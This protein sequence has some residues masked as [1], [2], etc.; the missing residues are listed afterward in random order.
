MLALPC[1]RSRAVFA[2][3]RRLYASRQT[4]LREKQRMENTIDRRNRN[5]DAGN[6]G[7]RCRRENDAIKS[8]LPRKSRGPLAY[9]R[10]LV[11]PLYVIV[12]SLMGSAVSMT[13]KVPEH[14][15]RALDP[16]EP[17][18]N[19]QAREYLVFQ[20]MQVLSAP[21]IG[22]LCTTS[23]WDRTNSDDHGSQYR[24]SDKIRECHCQ[25]DSL[26]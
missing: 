19:A 7:D 3:S 26:K 5:I 1:Y 18:T 17:L 24:R 23:D 16:K 12:L 11:V 14:Q 21:L 8:V 15:R 10:G 25:A 6:L 2:V 20:I 13:R 9:T 22:E 4:E